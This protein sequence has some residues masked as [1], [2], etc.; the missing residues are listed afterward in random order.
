MGIDNRTKKQLNDKSKLTTGIYALVEV[1]GKPKLMSSDKKGYWYEEEDRQK[2]KYRVPIKYL[3]NLLEEP[4]SL[5]NLSQLNIEYDKYLTEGFQGSSIPLKAKIF[6]DVTNLLNNMQTPQE[7]TNPIILKEG[8]TKTISV[9]LYERNP[10]ARQT[11]IE[12]Y[13]FTCSICEFNFYETY[14][15]I[16]EGFIHVHHI[17][18][19]SQIGK[20][21]EVNPIT[22]LRPVCP[23]CHAMLHK[24]NPP[25]SIDELKE[26]LY[27]E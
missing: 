8:A 22:D 25:Y 16:G 6:N 23:N 17:V 5:N 7:V 19:I 18:E 4:I 24:R 11:C 9:N 14:G 27:G 21:Y 2:A 12:H 13:G 1:I 10:L 3:F 26:I 15:E 20:E